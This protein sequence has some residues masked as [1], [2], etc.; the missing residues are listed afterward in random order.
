MKKSIAIKFE[1]PL[2]VRFC[3]IFKQTNNFGR[4]VIRISE[5]IVDLGIIIPSEFR[6]ENQLTSFKVRTF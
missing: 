2:K 1:S 3:H 4:W 6:S 5:K